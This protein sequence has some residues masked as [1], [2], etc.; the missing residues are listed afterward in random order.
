MKGYIFLMM[1][2]AVSSAIS[3]QPAEPEVVDFGEDKDI[4]DINKDSMK[5]DILELSTQR[6]A[7]TRNILWTSPVPYD[8]DKGLGIN[9]KGVVL[10]AFEQFRLKTCI[11]FKPKD[12]EE[13]YI[14]VQKLGGCFSYIGRVLTD[15][16]TLS[17]GQ[18]CDEIST[19][20]HEFLHA[21]GFYHE[22]SRYDRDDHVRIITENILE[23]FE[24]NFEKVSSEQ[25]TTQG[26]DYDYSSVMHYGKNAFTNGNGSTIVTLDPEFQDVIGQRLEMSPSDVLELNL[27]YECNST[28]ALNMFCGFSGTMC[29]MSRC[30]RGGIGW[31]MVTK[32][33]GGPSSDH[34]LLPGGS[35]DL[36]E[37]ESHFMHVSTESGEDGDSALLETERMSPKRDCNVQCL[38]F[39]YY[40]SG[41]ESDSLSIW[42][43]EF[44][45][46][47]DAVGTAKMMAQIT[48]STTSQW[49]LHH[50]PLTASKHFQV[51]FQV[52]KG[53]GSS[54]GGFSIDDINLSEVQRPHVTMQVDN[55]EEV[56]QTSAYGTTV[57]S[58]RQYSAGGYA[59]RTAVRFFRSFVGL[60][61]QLLSGD[62]D[63]TLE[64]PCPYRQA[65]FKM[66]D[67]NPDIQ[68]Q[69]SK[70]RSITSDPEA[71]SASGLYIWDNPRKN[72]TKILDENNEEA[73]AG[74][75]IGLNYF[76]S[77]EQVQ[78]R[79]FLKGKTAIFTFSFEDLNPLFEDNVLPCPAGNTAA[80]KHPVKVLNEGPCSRILQTTTMPP[81]ETTHMRTT[82]PILPPPQT[83]E[84]RSIFGFC[85]GLVASPVL[86]LLLALMLLLLP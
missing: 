10:K 53:A 51:E 9:A 12:S 5:D 83:T 34:T 32:A 7:T 79:E 61:V 40:H 73:Y 55:F 36:G 85:P 22:Q 23:G 11:D 20:E 67:Q 29:E 75:L 17:I 43:R 71:T 59:Y 8:L 80:N 13:Y 86:A 57:Y 72:G 15:G 3:L 44:E 74:P 62:N 4:A 69:M 33:R 81:S 48:G 19:V 45:D 56:L 49:K 31:E 77:L 2:L 30:S 58:P 38:Q 26:V 60:Y 24:G 39:Y 41:N 25:S 16:Q 46:E 28:V 78:F 65:T 35:G 27:L 6:S 64:W 42:M 37:G 84:D 76:S 21:L 63:D 1:H 68:M 52:L 18:Y 54:A 50:V 66:L 82:T 70:Q 47:E 14:S